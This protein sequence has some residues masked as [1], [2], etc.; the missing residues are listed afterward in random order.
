MKKIYNNRSKRALVFGNTMLLPGTN[1]A[2]EIDEKKFPLIKSLI[3]EGE[4]EVEEDTAKAVKSANTQKAVDDIVALSNGDKKT[5]E[6]ASKRKQQLDKIDEDAK[7]AEKAAAKE[8]EDDK[9]ESA[10]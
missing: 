8:E 10:E 3:D 9:D 6:A 1:T 2:E 5:K 7:K 4:V